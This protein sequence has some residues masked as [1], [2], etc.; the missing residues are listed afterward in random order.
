MSRVTIQRSNIQTSG[1]GITVPTFVVNPALRRSA[2]VRWDF[3]AWGGKYEDQIA[4]GKIP[5]DMN[6]W[7]DLPVLTRRLSSK[8]DRL[9]STGGVRY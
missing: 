1:S 6:R 4:D 2:M 3:N 8:A 7:L 9:M 5:A